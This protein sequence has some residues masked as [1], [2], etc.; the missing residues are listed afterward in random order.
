MPLGGAPR[1]AGRKGPGMLGLRKERWWCSWK[2]ERRAGLDHWPCPELLRALRSRGSQPVW[3]LRKHC[4]WL[5]AVWHGLQA[6][7]KKQGGRLEVAVV[8]TTPG[9][10]SDARKQAC[11]RHAL[12]VELAD[13]WSTEYGEKENESVSNTS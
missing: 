3:C 10:G 11:L 13:L 8:Y 9:G 6:A 4:S 7:D 2:W 12:A 1:P 5:A